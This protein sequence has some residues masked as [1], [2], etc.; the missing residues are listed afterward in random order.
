MKCIKCYSD[1]IIKYGLGRKWSQRIFCNKCHSTFTPIGTRWTYPR[2]F[3]EKIVH[4]YKHQHKTAKEVVSKNKI[5]SRTLIKRSKLLEK[6][7]CSFCR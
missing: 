4:Q 6:S 7:D 3:I 2:W 5:S 1:A